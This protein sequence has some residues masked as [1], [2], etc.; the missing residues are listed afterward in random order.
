MSNP[1]VLT[2][3]PDGT[4][5]V[6]WPEFDDSFNESMKFN[7]L[8]CI[9]KEVKCDEAGL[10]V[11]V[12]NNDETSVLWIKDDVF[13][14]EMTQEYTHYLYKYYKIRGAVFHKQQEAM[15]FKDVLEKRYMWQLLKE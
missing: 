2:D 14:T 3:L 13:Y 9:F 8:E 15:H 11:A 10:G 4:W 1:F 5:A 12:H 6:A 7:L